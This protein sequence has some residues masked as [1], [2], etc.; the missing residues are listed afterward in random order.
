MRPAPQHWH[1]KSERYIARLKGGGGSMNMTGLVSALWTPPT[2]K[3]GT[4]KPTEYESVRAKGAE[5]KSQKL[6]F[7][8]QLRVVYRGK[9]R[10]AS[11]AAAHP[12]DHREL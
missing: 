2:P 3:D 6:A 11:G 8:T 9:R 5:E 4:A 1:H 12:V 7:E 10:R